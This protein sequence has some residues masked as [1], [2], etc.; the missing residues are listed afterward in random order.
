ANDDVLPC[1]C[2]PYDWNHRLIAVVLGCQEYRTAVSL[3]HHRFVLNARTGESWSSVDHELA[4]FGSER[5]NCLCLLWM[6]NRSFPMRIRPIDLSG[7]ERP[8]VR[9]HLDPARIRLLGIESGQCDI[10]IAIFQEAFPDEEPSVRDD[11]RVLESK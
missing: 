7:D 10:P 2:G 6:W 5:D 9:R 3:D 11:D 4:G 8:L 1:R